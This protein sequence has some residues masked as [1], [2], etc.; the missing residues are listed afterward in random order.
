[1]RPEKHVQEIN[2]ARYPT[3]QTN[4]TPRVQ[5]DEIW[6]CL[7]G[8]SK[9]VHRLQFVRFTERMVFVKTP[10]KKGVRPYLHE[11]ITLIEK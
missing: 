9:T 3:Y 1:M 7:L 4:E 5:K 8:N 6:Y 2:S 10:G 11:M